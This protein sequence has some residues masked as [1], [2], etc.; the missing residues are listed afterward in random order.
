MPF[1][2][3]AKPITF[4]YFSTFYLGTN[5]DN[6][7]CVWWKK[8]E[9]KKKSRRHKRTNSLKYENDTKLTI[10]NLLQ[11]GI[12]KFNTLLEEKKFGKLKMVKRIKIEN[13]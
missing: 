13:V 5:E 10:R 8:Q 1:H 3:L 11:R 7:N 12:R 2:S 9:G 4:V 6:E